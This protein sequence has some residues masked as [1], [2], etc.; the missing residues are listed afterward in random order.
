[1]ILRYYRQIANVAQ[2]VEHVI[3]NDKVASSILAI[4]SRTIFSLTDTLFSFSMKNDTL[5]CSMKKILVAFLLVILVLLV[6]N[7]RN[8]DLALLTEGEI[9]DK[10]VQQIIDSVL[11]DQDPNLDF[12]VVCPTKKELIQICESIRHN[13]ESPLLLLDVPK[14]YYRSSCFYDLAHITGDE[15]LCSFAIERKSLF[16]NSYESP[17]R[18]LQEIQYLKAKFPER[19][20]EPTPQEYKVK[21][22]RQIF[23]DSYIEGS[24]L[25]NGTMGG[26]YELTVSVCPPL[27]YGEGDG[28]V[29]TC[30]DVYNTKLT[31]DS[32]EKKK[33]VNYTIPRDDFQKLVGNTQYDESKFDFRVWFKRIES[34]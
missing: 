23:R 16:R 26:D 33:I 3:R 5:L 17:S 4:G 29:L 31:L 1:M 15:S 12:L 10:K 21:T 8:Q 24:V 34:R 32:N 11:C 13:L 6:F 27:V 25:L 9:A 7:K 28:V 30:I 14:Y 20:L 18:C 22:Y 2:L 19:Y